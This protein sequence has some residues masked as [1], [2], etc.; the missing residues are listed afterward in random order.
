MVATDYLIKWVEAEALVNI[1]DMDVK[2][3]V[4][5]NIVTRFRVPWVLILDNE[6]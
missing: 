5:E 4:W 3:F 1:R 6:L 2:K